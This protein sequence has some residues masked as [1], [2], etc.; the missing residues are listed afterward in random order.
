M[1]R[2]NNILYLNDVMHALVDVITQNT[3]SG[4]HI[5]SGASGIGF[6]VEG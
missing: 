3:A 4:A 2:L 6:R 5:S 1:F